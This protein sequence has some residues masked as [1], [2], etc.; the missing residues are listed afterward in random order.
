[1]LTSP[2]SPS[3]LSNVWKWLPGR[4]DPSLAQWSRQEWLA[5]NFPDAPSCT[6][7]RLEWHLLFSPQEPPLIA[8]TFRSEWPHNDLLIWS[9][10]FYVSLQASLWWIQRSLSSM[11]FTFLIGRLVVLQ[12]YILYFYLQIC[13]CTKLTDITQS[14]AW[15]SRP[16]PTTMSKKKASQME[17]HLHSGS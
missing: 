2:K 4:F 12:Q 13:I 8:L 9:S 14:R 7:W 16:L 6:S 11:P 3:C 10:W 1:M 5:R 17:S 15:T